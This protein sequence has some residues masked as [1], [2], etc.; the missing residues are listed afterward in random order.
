[1]LVDWRNS[2]EKKKKNE[3]KKE[4]KKELLFF[5]S[6][7]EWRAIF[8]NRQETEKTNVGQMTDPWIQLTGLQDMNCSIKHRGIMLVIHFKPKSD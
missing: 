6:W 3:R 7:L 2:E 1:M 5:E 4:R 8:I